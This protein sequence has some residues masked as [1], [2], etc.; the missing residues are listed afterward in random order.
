MEFDISVFI[1]QKIAL[2]HHQEGWAMTKFDCWLNDGVDHCSCGLLFLWAFRNPFYF[3][4]VF[5]CNIFFVFHPCI[6]QNAQK[7]KLQREV[8]GYVSGKC[9][10]RLFFFSCKKKKKTNQSIL[11]VFCFSCSILPNMLVPKT[12]LAFLFS[13]LPYA[14]QGGHDK[15]Y[16]FHVIQ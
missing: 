3:L 11:R 12:A 13:L 8:A 15:F 6:L 5:Y 14:Y 10:Q 4:N 9:A 16:F 2:F 1:L 7:E